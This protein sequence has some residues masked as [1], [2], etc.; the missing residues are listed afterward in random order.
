MRCLATENADSSTRPIGSVER[1]GARRGDGEGAAA[2]W[3][4]RDYAFLALSS[5]GLRERQKNN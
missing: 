3:Q 1:C 4:T 5:S 2:G